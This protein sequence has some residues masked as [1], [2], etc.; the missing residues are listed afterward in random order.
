MHRCIA[1][2]R[3]FCIKFQL[4]SIAIVSLFAF[5]CTTQQEEKSF[6]SFS[7]K[8]VEANGYVVPQDSISSPKV[9]IAGNPKIILAKTPKEVLTNINIHI[10]GIPKIVLAGN[11]KMVISGEDS[12]ALPKKVLAINRPFLG[13]IP[14]IVQANNAYVKDQN[15]QNFSSFSKL[16]GLKHDVI[17]CILQDKNG[18]VWF[19]TDGGGASKYDGKYFTHYTEKEGLANNRVYSMLQDNAGNLWFG[20][21]AGGV[22]QF[23]G[24]YFTNFSEKEG[25]SNSCIRFIFQDS[26]GNIW[27]GTNSDGVYMYDGETMSEGKAGFTHYTK[28][29]GLSSNRVNSILQDKS[30]NIWFCTDGGVS[31]YNEK[32]LSSG[33]ATFTHFTEN[34]GLSSNNVSCVVE[35]SLGYLWFGT[36]GTGISKYDGKYFT[37][38]S[39]EEGLSSNQVN[40]ILQDDSGILWFG[41]NGGGVSKF[42]GNTFTH[43]TENEGLSNNNVLSILQDHSGN[44]WFGSFGGGVSKYYGKSMPTGQAGFT[45]F[46]EKEGLNSNRILSIIHSKS[47]NLWIGTLN[48][49]ASK[50]DGCRVEGAESGEEFSPQDHPNM[51]K[52]SEKHIK[53]L[54][55]RQAAF[56]YFTE[57]E[58]LNSTS[59]LSILEDSNGDIWF[60]TFGGGVYKYDGIYFSQFTTDEGLNSNII[61]CIIQDDIGNLWFGSYDGGIS[62]YDGLIQPAGQAT[63]TH[64]TQEQGLSDN[65]VLSILQDKNGSIWSGTDGG[66]VSRLDISSGEGFT[67]THF[68]QEQGLS[69]NRIYSILQD[70]DGFIW[71]GTD[72]GGISRY[73][74]NS[75][76]GE[77]ATFTHF[78]EKEGLVNNHVYS[79]LQDKR[80]NLWFG[81]GFGLSKLSQRNLGIRRSNPNEAVLNSSKKNNKI[82]PNLFKNYTYEDGFLGIGCNRGTICEDYSGTIWIG[83]NDRLTAFHPDG[84]DL[85]TIPPNIQLTGIDL[86]NESIPWVNLL[87]KEQNEIKDTSITLGNG[88]I[89]RDFIFD[90]TARWYGLPLNLSLRYNNNFIAFRYIGITQKQ[91]KQVKYQ[92]MLDGL[93]DGWSAPTIRNEAFYGNLP[94]GNYIFRVKAMNGE[95][96]WSNEY[97]YPFSIRPPWWKTWWFRVFGLSFLSSC[98]FGFYRWRIALL[99]R[100][101]LQLER[102]VMEKTAEVV[103][104][105][106]DLQAFNEELAATNEEIH[107]QTEQLH[108]QNEKLRE[109]D[110][111][112]Q[113]MMGMIV[114]DLKNPLNTILGLSKTPEIKQAGQQ[115]LNMVLNILDVQKFESAEMKLQPGRYNLMKCSSEAVQEVQ[116]LL[117]RK[118]IQLNHLVPLSIAI[119]ADSDLIVRVLVNI[120]TNAIKYTPN[121]GVITLQAEENSPPGFVRVSV[122]DTGQGIPEGMLHRVFDKFS[123]LEARNSGSVRSTGLGLAF[124]KMAVEAHGGEIGV[125]SEYGQGTTFWFLIPGAQAVEQELIEDGS[126][127]VNDIVAENGALAFI[128]SE[129]DQLSAYCA[130]FKEYSVYEFSDLVEILKTIDT[131]E[132]PRLA[133]WKQQ[134]E[135]A[136]RACNEERYSELINLKNDE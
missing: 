97:S 56:S 83:A 134:L 123:Q 106:K 55:N 124:C 58:G 23:D 100:Q 95:G 105:A 52:S 45:H 129:I 66:G 26:S 64:F 54:P 90:S 131:Q 10:A 120:L 80:G 15:P 91:S 46:T 3:I 84:D 53:Y 102:I 67:F 74:G 7:Q 133:L 16:Q 51:A 11:P 96:Y 41:T 92:Y 78:T 85:D 19:G 81:T 29:E 125:V 50:Y 24:K 69:D 107:A 43:F 48:M 112:K 61:Y 42:N 21:L 132:N 76:P 68:T 36:S 73:D 63:F 115:M 17:L 79:I 118:S 28:N 13:G 35:D 89:V 18:N 135:N 2:Y 49:G 9:V 6:I 126:L 114:H 75:L 108:D 71:F 57:K 60:G 40:T 14:E 127:P 77:K 25:L 39:K 38:Y 104:Q 20:T 110:E 88:V 101:K 8:V 122:S 30:G 111:F 98:L 27:F 93:D 62:K 117:D 103:L 94:H 121:N 130:L 82:L 47:G 72:G 128:P 12:C 33:R 109:M 4:F 70:N 34:E 32:D 1:N 37:N 86:Y 119:Q 99:R 116:M 31:K 87:T 5:S 113:G 59:I 65:R 22:T 136:I 44:L